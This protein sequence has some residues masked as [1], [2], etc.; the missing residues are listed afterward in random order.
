MRKNL[1]LIFFINLTVLLAEDIA[2]TSPLID[3]SVGVL[4]SFIKSLLLIAL[5]FALFVW[6]K[7]KILPGMSVQGGAQHNM[8]IV[9]K[10]MLDYTTTLYLVEVGGQYQV[11]G[12]SNK[13]IA[14]LNN[15]KGLVIK[16]AIEKKTVLPAF[17]A[18]LALLTGKT[19]EKKKK[20]RS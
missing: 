5:M 2:Y 10:L 17:K 6:W 8:K 1:L 20:V 13:N 15:L 16:T 3:G 18:Q 19:K 14:M 12:V 9:E 4:K 11:Y 7:R